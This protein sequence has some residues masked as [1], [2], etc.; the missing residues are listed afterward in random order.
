LR[1]IVHLRAR[2]DQGQRGGRGGQSEAAPAPSGLAT[3]RRRGLRPSGRRSRCRDVELRVGGLP[4]QLLRQPRVQALRESRGELAL[5]LQREQAPDLVLRLVFVA[6]GQTPCQV[7]TQQR[8][9]VAGQRLIVDR[10]LDQHARTLA[11]QHDG[12]PADSVSVGM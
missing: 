7:L 10:P 5:D 4:V 11:G 3:E 12:P 9:R 1:A 2:D 6:A 8:S